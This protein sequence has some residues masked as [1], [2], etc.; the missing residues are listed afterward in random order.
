MAKMSKIQMTTQ[1]RA[2][3]SSHL[4][5]ACEVLMR[6]GE[7]RLRVPCHIFSPATENLR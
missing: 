6:G 7:M 5:N 3:T 4:V 1:E 2:Y